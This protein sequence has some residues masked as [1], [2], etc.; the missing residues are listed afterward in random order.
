VTKEIV[1][2]ACGKR[3]N[4]KT[5]WRRLMAKELVAKVFGKRASSGEGLWQNPCDE[6]LSDELP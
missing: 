3:A 2:K 5:L 6:H 4:G 1:A